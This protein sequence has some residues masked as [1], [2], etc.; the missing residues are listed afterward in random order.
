MGIIA[1]LRGA[2]G[3]RMEST[4]LRSPATWFLEALWGRESASGVQVSEAVAMGL[5]AYYCGVNM[6]AGTIGSLPLNVYRRQGRKREVA[7]SHPAQYLLHRR[8]NPHMSAMSLRQT[9]VAH[10]I[11]RGNAYGELVFDGR[12][13]LL[14]IWPLLPTQTT[15]KLDEDNRL[16]YEIRVATGEV[17]YLPSERVLHIPGLGFDGIMGY[18]LI[19]VARDAIGL[20]AAENIYSAKFFRNGGS[21][22]GTIET[23]NTLNDKSFDRLKSE[24][25][26]KFSGLSNAHRVAILEAGLKYNPINP[27]H[28]DSQLIE[29]R[30][31]SI[32]EWARWLNM[33]PHKLKEMTHAT[34]SNIEHQNIEWM[35]DT[36]DP[37]LVRFEQEYDDKIFRKNN[38]FYTKHVVEGRLRGD[39]KTRFDS[40]AIARNWGWMSPNDVLELED[41]NPL[42]PDIGDVYL[43][44]ANMMRADQTLAPQREAAARIV[45][46]E[47]K[48]L[49]AR[50]MAGTYDEGFESRVMNLL[51]V[52]REAA[53]A[54]T[55]RAR[56]LNLFAKEQEL[57]E[58][59]VRENKVNLLLQLV[60]GGIPDDA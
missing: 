42:P 56:Q 8:P 50:G 55:A 25:A 2:A 44:P 22:S 13:N 1:R 57:S 41:R 54:Y 32:E 24:I 10:A 47:H 33:P 53:R 4:T 9:W 29:S 12:A 5:S 52:S 16:W 37:W 46:Q 60:C 18:G 48:S 40:Y 3:P 35:V 38:L 19:Q 36:I 34:F 7:S 43:I 26:D 59:A 14:E 39:Q 11:A 20:N 6:I 17:R 31:F 27:T 23:T 21:V 15:P 51:N 45:R 58:E 28:R 49:E 30:R